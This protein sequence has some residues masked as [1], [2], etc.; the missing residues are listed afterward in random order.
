[1]MFA[2]TLSILAAVCGLALVATSSDAA[3]ITPAG[4]DVTGT[5]QWQTAGYGDDFYAFAIVDDDENL[6]T[7]GNNA[8]DFAAA[9]VAEGG[10]AITT[11]AGTTPA[12][13]ETVGMVGVA[14]DFGVGAGSVASSLELTFN[15][16]QPTGVRLAV[17]IGAHE[18]TDSPDSTESIANVRDIPQ[19]LDINGVSV[20]TG[21]P[22]AFVT[23]RPDWYFFDITDIQA[24]D[25]VTIGG[26]HVDDSSADRFVPING[27]GVTIVPE[28]A[29]ATMIGLG[30]M[31]ILAR[32]RRA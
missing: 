17:L 16:A 22:E 31:L 15:V 20:A 24:G 23:T 29:S 21:G 13:L 4:S 26:T 11:V 14:F 10:D 27:F 25:V 7:G 28:P 12:N 3:V 5:T 1:M 9:H 19:S 30:G 18:V 32:R 2:R 8:A 6:T